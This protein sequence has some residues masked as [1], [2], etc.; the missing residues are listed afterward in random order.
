LRRQSADDIRHPVEKTARRS[1]ARN[2]ELAPDW[3]SFDSN[4][5]ACEADVLIKPEEQ[6]CRY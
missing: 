1:I 5:E 4:G 2:E 6:E 3:G